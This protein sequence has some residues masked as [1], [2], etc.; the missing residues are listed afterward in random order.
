MYRETIAP[1]LGV[2]NS[3]L[4]LANDSGEPIT[5][6]KLQK[7]TYFVYKKYL[8]DT[9]HALFDEYFEAWKY[10]PVLPSI[11]NEFKRFRAG[12]IEEY[13]YSDSDVYKSRLL[14]V[15]NQFT[16]FYGALHF[17]WGRYHDYDG[18]TL[19]ELTHAADTAWYKAR[20]KNM[21]Y[22]D[23]E[24]IAVERWLRK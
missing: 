1:G 15:D 23:D 17:V 10:G 8:Q 14:C 7:L 4:R 22:L 11:Y 19:S 13:A 24:D 5:P 20:K 18:I 12:R 2:A 3:I 9:S 16:S 21:L 6:M